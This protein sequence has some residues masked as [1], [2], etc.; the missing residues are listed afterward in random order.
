MRTTA[1]QNL[2]Q[3]LFVPNGYIIENQNWQLPYFI[4]LSD[5]QQID[6]SKFSLIINQDKT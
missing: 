6:Y 4:N 5:V 1:L 2:E 3:I